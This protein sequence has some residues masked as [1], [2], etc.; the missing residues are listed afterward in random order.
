[1]SETVEWAIALSETVEWAIAM[2]VAPLELYC[3]RPRIANRRRLGTSQ[4]LE[5]Y[6]AIGDNFSRYDLSFK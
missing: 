6:C 3:T 5:L 2:L 1:M 4:P